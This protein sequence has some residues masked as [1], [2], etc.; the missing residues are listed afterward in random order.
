MLN[1]L[2]KHSSA[3]NKIISKAESL[4]HV[5]FNRTINTFMTTNN[6]KSV[7]QSVTDEILE[8]NA[9]AIADLMHTNLGVNHDI[10]L[11]MV[12]MLKN[13]PLIILD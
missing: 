8:G 10:A 6:L 7:E 4:P 5:I 12:G 9:G 1:S 3:A 11:G 2:K 13:D